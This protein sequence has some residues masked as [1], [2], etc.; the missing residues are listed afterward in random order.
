[1]ESRHD[2]PD[3]VI[4]SAELYFIAIREKAAMDPYL[5]DDAIKFLEKTFVENCR[6]IG[7]DPDDRRTRMLYWTGA[8]LGSRVS[9]KR[10]CMYLKQRQWEDEQ[11]PPAPA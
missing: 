1:M 11:K 8:Y 9:W 2:L 5:V 7:A 4:D 10:Y 3:G 6:A